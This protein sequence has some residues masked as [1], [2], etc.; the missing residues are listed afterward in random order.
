MSDLRAILAELVAL[1]D[2]KHEELKLRSRR[3]CSIMRK[4]PALAKVNAMR[5]DYNRRKPLAWAAARHAVA[6]V[7][8]VEGLVR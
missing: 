6:H 4:R 2:L 5:D 7:D 8:D 3:E 1:H